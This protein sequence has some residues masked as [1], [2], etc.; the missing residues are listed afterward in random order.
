MVVYYSGSSKTEL[1]KTER[2]SKTKHFV[3][4]IWDGSDS[5]RS[6]IA[7]AMVQTIRNPYCS[8]RNM[9]EHE[10]DW[11]NKLMLNCKFG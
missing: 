11:T 3:V 4:R 5:E 2:H 7:I 9:N 6:V 1:G 8:V 10:F